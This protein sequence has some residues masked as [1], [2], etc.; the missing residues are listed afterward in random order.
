MQEI[1][2]WDARVLLRLFK[3]LEEHLAVAAVLHGAATGRVWVDA[4]LAPHSAVLWVQHRVFVAGE[5]VAGLNETVQEI[6]AAARARG[7]WGVG[8]YG[9]EG[10]NW[11]GVLAGLI[12]KIMMREY[13][14]I[15]REAWTPLVAA[16]PSAGLALRPAD[17]ALVTDAALGNV[18][19]LRAE[20]CSER[21]SVEDFL[22]RSFG[23]CLV[24]AEKGAL[25]GW[26]LSEYNCAER[27]EVG[28]EV[29]EEHQQRGWGTRL[30]K[31]LCA[32]AFAQ[33]GIRRVGW[34]CLA[35]NAAS[36][37]TARRAGLRLVKRYA[38]AVVMLAG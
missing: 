34:H 4:P 33:R 13:W 9:T 24:D 32:E 6:A 15:G 17:Q 2:S 23:V 27:C 26:C 7:D 11:E 12:W 25:A 20:M 36:G 28:I 22:A 37:A 16:Q 21:P 1:T 30:A 10:T 5:N 31:A 14:E 35:A 29:I 3:G 38:G 18:A 8:V 19:Q